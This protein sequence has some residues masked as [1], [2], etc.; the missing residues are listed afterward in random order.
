MA[1][2]DS[3]LVWLDLEMTG[4]DPDRCHILEIATAVTDE[5]LEVVAEGPTLVLHADDAALATLS[6]WSRVQFTTSG[7]LD[8]CRAS[9]LDC[10]AAEKETLAFLREHC[11]QGRSPLCGNSVHTDRAFLWRHMRKL[12]DF[13]HYRN[14]DVSTIK[15][16]VRRWYPDRFAPPPKAGLHEALSDV[17]DSIAELRYYRDA[18][19]APHSE[20][21]TGA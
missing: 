17:Y 2:S 21:P 13:L 14:L 12:H 1:A 7:L 10:A 4:L 6:E 8:R 19:L 9:T 18:F 15:E 20:R 3:H 5:D 11:R 16:V